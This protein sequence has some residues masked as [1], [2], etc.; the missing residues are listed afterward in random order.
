MSHQIELPD[1]IYSRL[2]GA[3][4]KEGTTPVGWLDKNLPPEVPMQGSPESQTMA[5][6]LRDFIGKYSSDGTLRASERVDEL[7]G[8][9]LEHKRREGRL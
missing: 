1:S 6:D 4:E 9:Y 8:E 3:A 5:D 7:F 2:T